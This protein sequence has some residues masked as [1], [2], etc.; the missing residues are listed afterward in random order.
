MAS[1]ASPAD[2]FRQEAAELLVQLETTLLD[3]EAEPGNKD[4]VDQAFRSLHTLKG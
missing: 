1:V 4:L 3:L 2:I